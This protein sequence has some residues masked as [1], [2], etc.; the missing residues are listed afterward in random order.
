MLM[1]AIKQKNQSIQ[2][3]HTTYTMA[4]KHIQKLSTS[5]PYDLAPP[6]SYIADNNDTLLLPTCHMKLP[7]WRMQRTLVC[8]PP[9]VARHKMIFL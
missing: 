4:S 8:F 9:P 5:S 6:S 1:K 3:E 2:I 7:D